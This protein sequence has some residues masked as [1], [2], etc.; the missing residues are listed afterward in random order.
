[1]FVRV[2]VGTVHIDHDQIERRKSTLFSYLCP[3]TSV[4]IRQIPYRIFVFPIARVT[5]PNVRGALIH[6][7]TC[8]LCRRIS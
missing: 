8:T 5:T 3:Q 4:D 1:M 2:Y 7:H 6:L